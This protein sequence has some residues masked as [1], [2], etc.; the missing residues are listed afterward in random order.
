LDNIAGS[1]EI[2][3]SS[4][5]E[6]SHGPEVGTDVDVFSGGKWVG[7]GLFVEV[8]TRSKAVPVFVGLSIVDVNE[9]EL[10]HALVALITS[11]MSK[12]TKT[13]GL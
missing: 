3:T 9:A 7:V 2:V 8:G 4:K 11:R 1:S 12:R 6:H 13:G 10:L 5:G